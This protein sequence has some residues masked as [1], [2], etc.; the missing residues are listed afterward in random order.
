[1][2]EIPF[3]DKDPFDIIPEGAY[4]SEVVEA[5]LLPTKDNPESLAGGNWYA[6]IVFRIIDQYTGKLITGRYNVKHSKPETQQIAQSCMRR[7]FKAVG[8]NPPAGTLNETKLQQLLSRPFMLKVSKDLSDYKVAKGTYDDPY[9][10][11]PRGYTA[12]DA[13]Q[14]QSQPQAPLMMGQK[15]KD[16]LAQKNAEFDSNNDDD[17]IP[18]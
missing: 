5:K 1:M 9:D 18:F 13:A 10:N 8:L 6:H 11:N 7:I 17:D 3:E 16:I 4:K 12:L 14:Q 15:E 2:I